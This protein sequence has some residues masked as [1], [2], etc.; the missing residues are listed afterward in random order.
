ML[1]QEV[2]NTL[3]E[4]VNPT[5]LLVEYG[6]VAGRASHFASGV[7]S[8]LSIFGGTLSLYTKLVHFLNTTGP[9]VNKVVYAY[10]GDI[11]L[12]IVYIHIYVYN[13]DQLEILQIYLQGVKRTKKY[14]QGEI[15]HLNPRFP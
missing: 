12:C 4:S 7:H 5:V 8:T 3:G 2:P 11:S 6:D 9:S 15:H 14:H 1:H 10:F 13:W